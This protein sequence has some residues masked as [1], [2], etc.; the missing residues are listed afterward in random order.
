MKNRASAQTLAALG[1]FTVFALGI[2]GVLLGG[3][4]AYRRLTARDRDT[5]DRGTALS[6]LAT[7]VRQAPEPENITVTDLEGV[8]ALS[9]G[10]TIEGR[11]YTTRVYCYEG[12]LMELFTLA[13][14]DFSPEDGEKLLPMQA[15]ECTLADDLLTLDATD[16]SGQTA[17]LYF[18]LREVGA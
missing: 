8:S 7:R 11:A 14:G 4:N 18:S 10:Q 13:E 5:Y 3:G 12:W 17:R 6:Y 9:F 16:S 15:L 1:L 2:L